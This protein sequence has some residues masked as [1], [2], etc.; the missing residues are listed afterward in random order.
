MLLLGPILPIVVARAA[1]AEPRQLLKLLRR[2]VR[3]RRGTQLVRQR[4]GRLRHHQKLIILVVTTR[5]CRLLLL[6]FRRFSAF[7]SMGLVDACDGA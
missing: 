7:G 1:P 3:V 2:H 6:I 5:H 4:L